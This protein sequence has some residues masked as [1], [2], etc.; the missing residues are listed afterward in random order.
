[1]AHSISESDV[2]ESPD[3]TGPILSRLRQAASLL[4]WEQGAV[5]VNA[6]KPFRLASGNVSPIYVDCRR[7]ISNRSVL[8][9]FTTV[10]G[11]LLE[12][13]GAEFDVVAGGETAG[14]PYAAVLAEA[15]AKPLVYVRKKAKAYGTTSRVEGQL[16]AGSR[17]LLVED[18]ITDGGSKLTFL[19]AIDDAGASVS[20]ALVLVAAWLTKS[21]SLTAERHKEIRAQIDA[22][23]SNLETPA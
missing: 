17:V 20:S 9:I 15:L 5:Q 1:M 11:M 14:I 18:L 3:L 7:V 12:R 21:Y 19:D 23:V 16:E 22:Q 10:A 4:L 6:E 2:G 8:R 13:H